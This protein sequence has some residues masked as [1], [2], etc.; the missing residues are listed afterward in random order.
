MEVYPL[1]Q[2]RNCD[3]TVAS[4]AFES[5]KFDRRLMGFRA[6]FKNFRDQ[7][8]RARSLLGWLTAIKILD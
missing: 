1:T 6:Q 2:R 7:Q 3:E 5:T 8:R 4:Q